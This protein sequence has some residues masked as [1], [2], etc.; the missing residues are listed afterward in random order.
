TKWL[1]H[2]GKDILLVAKV[3]GKLAGMCVA[4]VFH[5]W[6]YCSTL[7]VHAPF[8]KMGIGRKLTDAA[9]K[10]IQKLGIGYFALLVNEKNLPTI[11]FYKKLG[12]KEGYRHV[13]M[14]KK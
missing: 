10:R 11:S 13:W 7:Y 3:D 9:Y 1:K 14:Y 12:F 8:R 6:A 2:P 5:E 4:M